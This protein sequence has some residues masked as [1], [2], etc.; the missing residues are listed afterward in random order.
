MKWIAANIG[1]EKIV[2]KQGK[3]IGYFIADQ[4]SKFYQSGTF[5]K[6]LQFVQT[7]PQACTMKEKKTRNGLRLL[8]V[9][10]KVG[11][12]DK[13]LRLLNPILNGS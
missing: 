7:H 9:F 6:T 12:V 11:S 13:A 4:Q 3:L 8:L 5:T 2:L 10:E 1:L